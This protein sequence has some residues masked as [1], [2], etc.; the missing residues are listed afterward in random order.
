MTRHSFYGWGKGVTLHFVIKLVASCLCVLWTNSGIVYADGDLTCPSFSPKTEGLLP[1][2]GL[3]ANDT[4]GCPWG[5]NLFTQYSE[6]AWVPYVLCGAA[7]NCTKFEDSNAFDKRG[8]E[9]GFKKGYSDWEEHDWYVMTECYQPIPDWGSRYVQT[10]AVP[11]GRSRLVAISARKGNKNTLS[12]VRYFGDFFKLNKYL[13]YI[14]LYLDAEVGVKNFTNSTF[15]GLQYLHELE[16]DTLDEDKVMGKD[17]YNILMNS[18][19]GM[20]DN[21]PSLRKVTF[22]GILIPSW[23]NFS[24]FAN[25]T[26]LKASIEDVSSDLYWSSLCNSMVNIIHIELVSVIPIHAK[27]P[28]GCFKN[29]T[30]LFEIRLKPTEGSRIKLY[31]VDWPDSTSY[32]ELY[33]ID[34]GSFDFYQLLMMEKIGSIYLK[35]SGLIDGKP[36]SNLTLNSTMLRAPSF[37]AMCNFGLTS[38]PKF[39]ENSSLTEVDLSDNDIEVLDV[40]NMNWIFRIFLKRNSVS[41]IVRPSS[42]S[43]SDNSSSDQLQ[44][45]FLTGNMLTPESGIENLPNT[46]EFLDISNNP[47]G[48]LKKKSFSTQTSL[49]FLNA[50]N[51]S[52]TEIEKD[53]LGSSPIDI[54]D[55]SHNP[56]KRLVH[57]FLARNPDRRIDSLMAVILSYCELE[58]VSSEVLSFT[59][60]PIWNFDHNNLADITFLNHVY[61]MYSHLDF[62]HN[63][64]S[65]VDL[66]ECMGC[67]FLERIDVSFNHI[68]S[69][70][71]LRLPLSNFETLQKLSLSHNRLEKIEE[72][73]IFNVQLAGKRGWPL[74]LSSLDLSHNRI[75]FIEPYS[76]MNCDFQELDL[77]YN[78]L[79]NL[80]DDILV[81]CT[82]SNAPF[83]LDLSFNLLEEVNFNKSF[84]NMSFYNIQLSGN[85]LTQIPYYNF[86]SHQRISN[87]SFHS[88]AFVMNLT[89]NNISHLELSSDYEFESTRFNHWRFLLLRENNISIVPFS[90]W[91]SS[92]FE[93]LDFSNNNIASMPV[94]RRDL[95]KHNV[96]DSG[97]VSHLVGVFLNNNPLEALPFDIYEDSPFLRYFGAL[98]DSEDPMLCSKMGIGNLNY[99]PIMN[100]VRDVDGLIYAFNARDKECFNANNLERVGDFVDGAY[101]KLFNSSIY[102][103]ATCRYQKPIEFPSCF[104]CRSCDSFLQPNQT[105]AVSDAAILYSQQSTLWSCNG[106]CSPGQSRP[107]IELSCNPKAYCTQTDFRDPT[108]KGRSFSAGVCVCYDTVSGDGYECGNIPPI[109]TPSFDGLVLGLVFSL[110][111]VIYFLV[112]FICLVYMNYEFFEETFGFTLVY[113][114]TSVSSEHTTEHAENRPEAQA[115][116][117]GNGFDWSHTAYS[118]LPGLYKQ[119]GA[120]YSDSTE[121]YNDYEPTDDANANENTIAYCYEYQYKYE[122]QESY[123]EHYIMT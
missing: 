51:C 98:K 85:R 123:I 37:F 64:I 83:K 45:L 27:F 40:S 81:N 17:T 103:T 80:E 93:V 44:N 75:S 94:L 95:I 77:S 74:H 15:S 111:V 14:G 11:D 34:I 71:D 24:V 12:Q 114:K 56:L 72:S 91:S 108:R 104:E 61:I 38:F 68:R 22:N 6:D 65:V 23:T 29:W 8:F 4:C 102:V 121:L 119:R 84:K 57:P 10:F 25:I 113:R 18:E 2:V 109:A 54:I 105:I 53:A 67:A 43:V 52:L 7:C 101:Q 117:W 97:N 120:L 79:T 16:F 122:V 26:S 78:L 21:L 66:S 9:D 88:E 42:F 118:S 69:L 19:H 82:S 41:K 99:V 13:Y 58:E 70:K 90:L 107:C 48:S 3:R 30:S 36:L 60:V 112:V 1:S 39:P 116:D 46:L 55:L 106:G 28:S 49:L 100:Q 73:G 50:S 86:L 62:S 59:L 110:Q 63:Q 33:H 76:F 20:F 87:Q 96:G 92:G 31:N 35:G 32:V 89:K 5:D 115:Y 47:L